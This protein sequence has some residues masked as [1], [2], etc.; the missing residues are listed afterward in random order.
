MYEVAWIT[1][2]CSVRQR[3]SIC[4]RVDKEAKSDVG[5]RNEVVDGVLPTDKWADGMDEPRT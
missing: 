2:E 4:S 5:N 1:G 3:S